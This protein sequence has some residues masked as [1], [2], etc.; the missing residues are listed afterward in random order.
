MSKKILKDEPLLSEEDANILAE[1][2]ASKLII[3]KLSKSI[4]GK[5]VFGVVLEIL[6]E[7]KS[8]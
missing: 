7:H 2:I 8:L 6:S 3:E 5:T 1:I 4:K